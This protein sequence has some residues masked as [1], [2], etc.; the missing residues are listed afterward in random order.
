MAVPRSWR[1]TVHERRIGLIDEFI[2]EAA[3]DATTPIE[4]MPMFAT[5]TILNRPRHRRTALG[6]LLTTIDAATQSHSADSH[7]ARAVAEALQP[8][9]GDP[10]LL[11]PEHCR[12]S[13]DG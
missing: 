8:A 12:S 5:A 6:R 2:K 3:P 7:R 10:A 4:R 11:Q 13:P 9:L 1:R